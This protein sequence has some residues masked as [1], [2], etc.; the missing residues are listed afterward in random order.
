MTNNCYK[1]FFLRLEKKHLTMH[2]KIAL[3]TEVTFLLKAASPFK[4]IGF[5]LL[6]DYRLPLPLHYIKLHSAI[7][8]HEEAVQIFR[9][10][11]LMKSI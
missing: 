4:S 3:S 1:T 8:I 6:A 11:D 10:P 5:L 7:K 2:C 9:W